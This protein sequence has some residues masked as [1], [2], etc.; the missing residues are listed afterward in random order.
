MATSQPSPSSGS[1]SNR[2][3][4]FDRFLNSAPPTSNGITVSIVG[5]MHRAMMRNNVPMSD[6]H[7]QAATDSIR[8]GDGLCQYLWAENLHVLD[9]QGNGFAYN[10]GYQ[11]HSTIR[12]THTAVT[13]PETWTSPSG[14]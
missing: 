14:S 10:A 5:F 1:D 8:R 6:G 2:R 4:D 9:S 3:Q 7:Y 13:N 12:S 11:F